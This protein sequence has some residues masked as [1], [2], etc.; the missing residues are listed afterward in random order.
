ML[1]ITVL[2]ISRLRRSS[3]S[4]RSSVAPRASVAPAR[5]PPV[6]ASVPGGGIGGV[7]TSPGLGVVA[8]LDGAPAALGRDPAAGADR[9]GTV[10]PALP[11][12]ATEGGAGAVADDGVVEDEGALEPACP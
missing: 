3:R 12:G 7:A 10:A 9:A 2:L 6:L 4:S 11:D 8:R 1:C 5:G